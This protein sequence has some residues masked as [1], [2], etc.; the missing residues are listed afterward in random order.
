MACPFK[1]SLLDATATRK[2]NAW[3]QCPLPKETVSALTE[4]VV[5]NPDFFHFGHDYFLSIC[6]PRYK[7]FFWGTA[8]PLEVRDSITDG[9]SDS[10]AQP[11]VCNS[12][13]IVDLDNPSSDDQN[14]IK[15][16]G[17]MLICF[18]SFLRFLTA[19]TES[20]SR[21]QVHPLHTLYNSLQGP[22]QNV[23]VKDT[24][25]VTGAEK[26]NILGLC[27]FHTLEN[28]SSGEFMTL[29]INVNQCQS[30]TDQSRLNLSIYVLPLL[31]LYHFHGLKILDM[32]L[33]P[34][35]CFALYTYP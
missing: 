19:E 14:K 3:D 1:H 29:W 22:R 15:V 13:G 33:L 9:P 11:F 27:L 25:K 20:T 34:Y 32:Q 31:K 16:L 8:G 2:M 23:P 24:I 21:V 12:V 7:P 6:F 4:A 26:G 18:P 17:S 30:V 5:I 35:N 28:I 10:A